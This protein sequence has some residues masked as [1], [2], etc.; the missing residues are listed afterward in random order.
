[1]DYPAAMGRLFE[2]KRHAFEPGVERTERV[3]AELDHPQRS[4]PSVQIAGTN[5][6]GST[7]AM[8]A[9]IL[10][11]A[12]YTV[13]L[14][15]SPHLESFHERIRVDG[16]PIT[17]AAIA[18]FVSA[19]DE[20][21]VDASVGEEDPTFFEVTT[22][23]ALWYFAERDVDFAVVEVGI[24]GANDATS[25]VDPIAAGITAIS[26]EHTDV[27][28]DTVEEI[29]TDKAAVAPAEGTLVTGVTG[30]AREVI[31]ARV[32]EA[33]LVGTD[34]ASAIRVEYRGVGDHLEAAI[35]IEV[36]DVTIDARSPLLGEAQA[37]NA[38]IAAGLAIELV[39]PTP[40]TI[41]RGIRS[42]DWPGRTEVVARD[43]L[44]VLDGAHNPAAT[45]HLASVLDELDV[46]DLHLVFGAMRDKDIP[47]MA[48]N[49]TGVDEVIACRPATP[50]ASPVS[51]IERAFTDVGVERVTAEATV[52]DALERAIARADRHDALVVTGSL[53]T[54]GEARTRW[55]RTVTS[56]RVHSPPDAAAAL[57]RI[58]AAPDS[59]DRHDTDFV[60]RVLQ[61]HLRPT[62][63]RHLADE[64][65]RVGGTAVGSALEMADNPSGLLL[66]G[67]H[68]AFATLLER[69]EA[70]G[71]STA[72][73]ADE[74][75]VA[76]EGPPTPSPPP[77]WGRSPVVMGIV[78]P[79]P[80]SFHD[81]GRFDTSEAAIQRAERLIEEGAAIIDVGGESTRPGG[82]E[83]PVDE[84]LGRVL[85]VIEAVADRDVLVS[86]DTRK[87][88]VAEV[89]LEA[90]AGMINDVSGLED[91][92]LLDVAGAY[93]VPLVLMHSHATPVDPTTRHEHDDI[94]EE[95]KRELG[96]LIRRCERFGLDRS[97]LVVD[98]GIGFGKTKRENFELL[99]RLD[100]LH[101]LGCPLLVGHS[102]KSMFDVV[103]LEAGDARRPGTVA[104]TAMAVERGADIVRVHDVA[105]NVAAVKTAAVFRSL[106]P[107]RTD[108]R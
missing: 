98:P 15:T 59:I 17:E 42:T 1:M 34:P 51:T 100:E 102:N 83:I 68:A 8:L 64:L 19:I 47:A 81:G 40:E 50:R 103:G 58:H 55:T 74:L 85:P 35:R 18:R 62:R 60:Y 72:H 39:S 88:E 94:V 54:V 73:L 66:G 67:T 29:A 61:T 105:E 43:P 32:P 24:G 3:L 77:P 65:T 10:G 37:V 90:G 41:A 28:G 97:S 86:V 89:A 27:L 22:A 2:L 49:L 13:G 84:E 78:N 91:P 93:D 38:G 45:A 44:V 20:H 82:E 107:A 69:L 30:P 31:T 70:M 108:T 52:A 21:L 80:D 79:T 76:I 11:Q 16:R 101:A 26:L 63:A 46:G 56:R 33:T 7:A 99:D 4:F 96:R 104:A 106:A 14:Y 23:M 57:G 6:K 25:V 53:F 75:R 71:P 87:A 5:G 92:D 95:V 12:G 9:S 36:D 48:A